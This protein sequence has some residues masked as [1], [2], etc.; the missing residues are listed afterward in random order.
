MVVIFA[1]ALAF[2]LSPRALVIAH[3]SCAWM[4]LAIALYAMF[5]RSRRFAEARYSELAAY[6]GVLLGELGMVYALS[7]DEAVLGWPAHT[8]LFDIVIILVSYSTFAFLSNFP[9]SRY[10]WRCCSRSTSPRWPRWAF[11][12]RPRPSTCSAC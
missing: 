4:L 3:L 6:L 9:H 7:L 5:A 11:R 10:G 2:I 8:V 12:R 1:I